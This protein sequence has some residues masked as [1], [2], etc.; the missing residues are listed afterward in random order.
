VVQ[1]VTQQLPHTHTL[2]EVMAEEKINT[3]Q[4]A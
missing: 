4:H 2:Q 3:L 1:A